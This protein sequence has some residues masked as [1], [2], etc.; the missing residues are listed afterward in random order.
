MKK[1]V[2]FLFVTFLVFGILV[3]TSIILAQNENDSNSTNSSNS[4]NTSY[5][6]KTEV[7]LSDDENDDDSDDDGNDDSDDDSN[8]GRGN[9]DDRDDS[10]KNRSDRGSSNVNGERGNRTSVI[11]REIM[12]RDNCTIKI[13]RK[14]EIKDG[15]RIEVVK[16]K[17]ECADGTR[18]EIQIRIENRTDGDGRIREKIHYKINND[19]HDVEVEE[20]IELEEET[21]GTEYKLK[22][23]LRNGNVTH[24]KIMPDRASQIAIDRLRALNF[25]VELREIEHRNIPRVVYHI[26]SNKTGRF[27]GVFKLAMKVEGQ[28]DPETGEFLGTSKPWWAFLVAGEDSDQ[29][30]D[31]EDNDDS[32]EETNVTINLLEQNDSNESGTATLTESNNQTTVTINM[33]GFT[34]NVS[35][36]AHI[37]MGSCPNV[38]SVVYPLTNVLNGESTT[39]LNATLDQIEDQLPLGINIHKSVNESSVYTACGD[40]QF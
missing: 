25:T 38:T 16:R 4:T 17:I 33:T 29:T 31:D 22:A 23:R 19:E 32:D 14:I 30:D 20:E 10:N 6:V 40:L 28:I 34:E 2:L 24:I 1:E 35:Q 36:P 39:I 7:N 18:G 12:N 3:N 11:S 15:K 5:T 13:E 9:D 21:N 37:H 8:S 27:L 26:E